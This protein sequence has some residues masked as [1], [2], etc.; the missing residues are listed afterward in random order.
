MTTAD[1]LDITQMP[2]YLWDSLQHEDAANTAEIVDSCYTEF[3]TPTVKLSDDTL[4]RP[5]LF[6]GHTLAPQTSHLTSRP[7]SATPAWVFPVLL[8]LVGAITLFYRQRKLLL[9][10][11][12]HA[13]VDSHA[14][15]RL[16]RN[17]SLLHTSQLVPMGILMLTC[18]ALPVHQLA[19]AKSGFGGYLL[20]TVALIAAYLI[21]NGLM[22]L[23]GSIYEN[24]AALG[25]YITSNY[26]YHFI[27]ATAGL[28]L[29]FPLFYIPYG[30]PVFLYVLA[31]LLLLELL[32]RLFRSMQLFL[33]QS[34]GPKFYLFYYLCIVEIAPILILIFCI[35]E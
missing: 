19:L 8:L 16:Q 5:S 33:T 30:K 22:R 12:L 20:L 28:P 3:L 23:L 15:D 17:N 27:L 29:L 26:F 9:R 34:S 18:L 6:A 10:D 11:L 13:L 25:A 4:E 21:R 35:I 1:T 2:F 14:M 24:N 7:D 32:I 31:G